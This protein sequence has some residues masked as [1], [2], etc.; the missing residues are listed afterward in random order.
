[1]A[2]ARQFIIDGACA[3][4]ERF[5]H[6]EWRSINERNERLQLRPASRPAIHSFGGVV[7]YTSEATNYD[8]VL[9]HVRLLHKWGRGGGLPAQMQEV[10]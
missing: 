1:M 8:W 7:V 3:Q 10:V 2:Q 6:D 4:W 9:R 5:H